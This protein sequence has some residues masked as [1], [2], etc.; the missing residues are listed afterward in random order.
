MSSMWNRDVGAVVALTVRRQWAAGRVSRS[1][2]W[3]PADVLEVTSA[4]SREQ[5][6]VGAP[7][8]V[9]RAAAAVNVYASLFLPWVWQLD[10][11][12]VWDP[13]ALTF[14]RGEESLVDFLWAEAWQVPLPR[15]ADLAQA[16]ARLR[17]LDLLRPQASREYVDGEHVPLRL[18]GAC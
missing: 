2:G 18:P 16:G 4:V 9:M 3:S 7:A 11:A 13:R 1:A 15:T 6:L 17:L 12:A 10:T 5:G 14:H 8:L